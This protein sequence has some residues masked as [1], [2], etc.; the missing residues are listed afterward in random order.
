MKNFLKFLSILKI[1]QAIL[2][3]LDPIISRDTKESIQTDKEV[4]VLPLGK[5]NALSREESENLSR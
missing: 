2:V 4:F 3:S 5:T 1:I